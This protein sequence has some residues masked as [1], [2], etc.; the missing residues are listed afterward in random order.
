M[1]QEEPEKWDEYQ[2]KPYSDLNQTNKE[3]DIEH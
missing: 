2:F 1:Q 3:L